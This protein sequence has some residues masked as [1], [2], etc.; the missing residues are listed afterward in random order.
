MYTMIVG[1]ISPFR[2]SNA[3]S[4]SNQLPPLS[5]PSLLKSTHLRMDLQRGVYISPGWKSK[6]GRLGSTVLPNAAEMTRSDLGYCSVGG[7]PACHML[8][9]PLIDP[10]ESI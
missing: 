9:Y 6:R 5:L 7:F 2:V 8:C 10:L 3:Y 1:L 4:H